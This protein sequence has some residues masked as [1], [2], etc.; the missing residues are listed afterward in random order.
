MAKSFR[1]WVLAAEVT[2][3]PVGDFIADA[4]RV[5]A[6]DPPLGNLNFWARWIRG[7]PSLR[8]YLE[9]NHACQECLDAVPD[10]WARYRA[11]KCQG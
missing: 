5:I 7:K 3:D 2:D 10:I 6:M 11:W 9:M 1:D 8:Q 4:R